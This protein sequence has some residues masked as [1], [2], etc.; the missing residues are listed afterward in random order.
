[1]KINK[2]LLISKYYQTKRLLA[3]YEAEIIKRGLLAEVDYSEFRVINSRNIINLCEKHF[4]V[5]FNTKS[6]KNKFVVAKHIARYLLSKYT[7][8][9]YEQ[10]TEKTGCINHTSV[11]NSKKVVQNW[12]DTNDRRAFHIYNLE[13]ELKQS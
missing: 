3:E 8:L 6:R 13:E 7:K 10:I 1:M 5:E 9:S 12:F 11:I 4:E 2:T